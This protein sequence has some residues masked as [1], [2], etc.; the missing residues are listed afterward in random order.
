MREPGVE[1]GRLAALDP[2]S[3]AS[4]N[5]ATLACQSRRANKA[6]E[7]QLHPAVHLPQPTQLVFARRLWPCQQSKTYALQV[8][9]ARALPSSASVLGPRGQ[10][11]RNQR[12][13]SCLE[14]TRAARAAEKRPYPAAGHAF[15]VDLLEGFSIIRRLSFSCGT[16]PPARKSAGTTAF[17]G[18]TATTDPMI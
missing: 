5:S 8:S 14:I 10:A 18:V 7:L 1:P 3:S 16:G 12:Q 4:A 11:K 6:I 13:L 2:K 17:S 9:D 15:G